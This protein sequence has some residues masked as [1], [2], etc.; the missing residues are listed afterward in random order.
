[1]QT[2]KRY[3]APPDLNFKVKQKCAARDINLSCTFERYTLNRIPALTVQ[4]CQPEGFF[5]VSLKPQV[6][7][8]ALFRFDK[9]C[10]P[11]TLEV[12]KRK[13]LSLL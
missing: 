4:K 6:L 12:N 3:N 2:K 1:M 8:K 11:T 13:D 7:V 10:S 9:E 5:L